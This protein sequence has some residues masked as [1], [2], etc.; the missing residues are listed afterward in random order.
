[1]ATDGAYSLLIL[2]FASGQTAMLHVF[3]VVTILPMAWF[4]GWAMERHDDGSI[5]TSW[6]IHSGANFGTM[7]YFGLWVPTVALS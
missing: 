5:L 7:V 6:L 3:V 2:F 4:S 1:M